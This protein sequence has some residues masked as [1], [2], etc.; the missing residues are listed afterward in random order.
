MAVTRKEVA[1]RAG[2]SVAVVSY[3]LNNKS[4]VKEETRRKVIEAMEELGYQPNL[5]ARSLKTKK[6]NQLAILTNYFGD[7][8]ES[9]VLLHLE[10][11]ARRHGYTMFFQPYIEE[12]E[13]QLKSQFMGRIDGLI[14]L[15]QSLKKSTV[16]HFRN[17]HIPMLSVTTPIEGHDDVPVIDMDWEQAYAELIRH[18]KAQG[19]RHIAYMSNGN[20]RHH[21]EHRLHSFVRAMK[22][23]K[24]H[25]EPDFLFAGGEGRLEATHLLMRQRL[26]ELSPDLPFTAIVCANDLMATGVLAACRE[27]GTDVPGRLA[28]AGSEDILMSSHTYPPLTT[29]QYPRR[30]LG[31]A[32][33][34]MLLKQMEGENVGN[35]TLQARLEIRC[36]TLAMY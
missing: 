4:F 35:L 2:V 8:F 11:A 18:L 21:H 17:N 10:S 7:P 5:M 26:A 25:V 15:G 3:V 30:R 36:S 16:D 28:I 32:A 29:I 23:E 9:G 13:E 19:H 31:N 33:V 12:Q 24:C 20:G 6:T 1:E 14:L 27:V 34:P 22:S